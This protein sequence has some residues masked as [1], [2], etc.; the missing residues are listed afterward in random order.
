MGRSTSRSIRA[1]MLLAVAAVIA[2]PALSGAHPEHPTLFPTVEQAKAGKVPAYRTTGPSLVVCQRDSGTR[3]KQIFGAK[4]H[5]RSARLRRQLKLL[6]RCHYRS[7][8]SAVNHAKSGYRIEILP[9]EYTEPA[10][11]AVPIGA[12][13]QPP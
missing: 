2:V 4:K 6:K 1:T 9:G 13:H 3:I 11:R 12:Y 8:Q 7:I 10:S 5:P